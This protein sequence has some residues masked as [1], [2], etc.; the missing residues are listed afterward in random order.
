MPI[1]LRRIRIHGAPISPSGFNLR[2]PKPQVTLDTG[3]KSHISLADFFCCADTE[4]WSKLF[5][6]DS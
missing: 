1:I 6:F 2:K 4:N 3:S 5:Q